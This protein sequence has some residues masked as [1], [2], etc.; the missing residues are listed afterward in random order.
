MEQI[1]SN[2]EQQELRDEVVDLGTRYGIVTPYTSYLALETV[3]GTQN[4]TRQQTFGLMGGRRSANAPAPPPAPADA[5]AVTGVAA[6]TESRR[7]RTQQEAFK[8]DSDSLSSQVRMM[9]GKTFYLREGVWTDSEFKP[10]STQ[11]ETVVKFASDEYFDLLKQ[12]PRLGDFFSL[13]E[14]VIVVFEGRVYRVNAS[15]P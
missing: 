10:G 5:K 8:L 9:G 4:V 7:A 15:T 1:R 13:G 3:A 12:K 14:K 11:P 2:G 6:V